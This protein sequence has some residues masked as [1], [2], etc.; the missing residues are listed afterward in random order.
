[1]IGLASKKK[2]M[3][4]LLEDTNQR[5]KADIEIIAG[6]INTFKYFKFPSWSGMMLITEKA[7]FK[8]LTTDIQWTFKDKRLPERFLSKHKVDAI[9]IRQQSL[10]S[11]TSWSLDVPG[12]DHIPVFANITLPA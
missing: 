9:F 8:D 3:T 5:K 1:M 2:Q 10:F 12:S 7:A 11:Y 6:D 4:F